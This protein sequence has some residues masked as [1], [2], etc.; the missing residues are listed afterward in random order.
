MILL[1]YTIMIKCIK[2]LG[3][4][5]AQVTEKILSGTKNLNWLIN[6]VKTSDESYSS[7]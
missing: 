1:F 5:H 7:Q 4:G 3:V 2:V 6:A